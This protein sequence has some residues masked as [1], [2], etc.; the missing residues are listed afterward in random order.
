MADEIEREPI[1]Q[2]QVGLS[3]SEI[4]TD[5]SRQLVAALATGGDS[6]LRTTDAYEHYAAEISV[7]IELGDVDPHTYRRT[8]TIPR[9][10][11]AEVRARCGLVAPS[12]VREER[13]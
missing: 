11:A 7:Q 4:L 9:A 6:F 8:V 5:L 12:L 1:E 2:V 13:V 3:Q 10:A